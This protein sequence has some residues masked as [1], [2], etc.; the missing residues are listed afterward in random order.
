M[1]LAVAI[2]LI[3]AGP[4][5]PAV[6]EPAFTG[7]IVSTYPD[8]RTAMLW[9]DA[10]GGYRAVGRR[11]KPS[12]GVWTLKGERVCLKQTKPIGAPFGYCTP[13]PSGTNWTARAVTGE[14]V[15]VRLEAGGR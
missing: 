5:A 11:R 2:A 6:L 12:S 9:L 14:T 8:G 1:P 7:T 3:L 10:D 15:K 4:A 13:L